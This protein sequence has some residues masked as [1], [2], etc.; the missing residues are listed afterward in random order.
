MTCNVTA[1]DLA[2]MN[3]AKSDQLDAVDLLA[4]P[5]VV[6][7]TAVQRG[8]SAEQ[9][10]DIG[11]SDRK[12]PWRPCLTMRRLMAAAWGDD[13]A[14]WLSKWVR[15]GRDPS[16]EWGKKAVGGVRILAMSAMTNPP[17]FTIQTGRG[18]W[19][20]F[21]PDMLEPPTLPFR[22]Q[23]QALIRAGVCTQDQAMERL[24][25]RKAAD[26]PQAEHAAI[27]ADLRAGPKQDGGEE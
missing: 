23:I 13:P 1:A 11:I 6:R 9:P 22:E 14:G 25:G 10:M 15:L 3:V 17:P 18:K 4:A 8:K 24:G 16:V 12:V 19:S 7:I 27:L 21:R 2:A 5:I 20:E 26:V